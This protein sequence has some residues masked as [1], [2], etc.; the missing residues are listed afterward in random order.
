MSVARQPS[1]IFKDGPHPNAANLF[2][3]FMHSQEGQPVWVDKQNCISARDDVTYAPGIPKLTEVK[4]IL[5][6]AN[7]VEPKREE[8]KDKFKDIFGS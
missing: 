3:D 6:D 1:A 2:Q 4:Y 8:V 5:L 7:V